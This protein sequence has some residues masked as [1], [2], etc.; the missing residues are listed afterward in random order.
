M[1]E[2]QTLVGEAQKSARDILAETRDSL[3][4]QAAKTLDELR[5]QVSDFSARL[6]TKLLKG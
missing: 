5:N 1:V 2:Q 3:R 4:A 6:A